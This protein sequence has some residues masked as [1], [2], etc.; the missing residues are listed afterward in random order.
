MREY[1]DG[2]QTNR[3]VGGHRIKVFFNRKHDARLVLQGLRFLGALGN[4]ARRSGVSYEMVAY[5]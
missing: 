4:L 3:L 2:K 1:A 5:R